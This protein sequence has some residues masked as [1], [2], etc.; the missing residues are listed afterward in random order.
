LPRQRKKTG[1][2]FKVR[3]EN[4]P[5]RPH[6]RFALAIDLVHQAQERL[7]RLGIAQEVAVVDLPD[8]GLAFRDLARPALLRDRD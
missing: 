2:R 6:A 3:S 4:V 1:S 7:H 5:G 8:E